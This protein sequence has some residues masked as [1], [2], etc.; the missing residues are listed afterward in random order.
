MTALLVGL[1]LA[2]VVGNVWM[3]FIAREAD[4]AVIEA[5]LV[6][7]EAQDALVKVDGQLKKLRAE[8]RAIRRNEK[9]DTERPRLQ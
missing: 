3:W 4:A 5:G 9:S 1:L 2:S 6:L 8:V 7:A